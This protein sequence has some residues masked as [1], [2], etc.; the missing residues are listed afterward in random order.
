[1]SSFP[2]HLVIVRAGDRSLHPTWT[3]TPATRTWDLVISYFDND[4]NRFGD[5]PDRRIDDPGLK[6]PGLHA[7]LVRETFWRD[8]DYIW[9]PD[10]D[11]KMAQEGVDALFREMAA[12]DLD[13]AQP[14][15]SLAS[16]FSHSITLHHPHFRARYT[17]FVEIMAPCFRREFLETCLPAFAESVSG[18]GLDWVFPSLRRDAAH[19]CAILDSIEMT[20]TRP[21]GGPSYAVLRERGITAQQEA[22]AVRARYGITPGATPRVLG[23]VT[24][25]G[26]R[27]DGKRPA[28]AAVLEILLANDLQALFAAQARFA[29]EPV[30]FQLL[31]RLVPTRWGW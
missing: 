18:W 7:L 9:L 15:L 3:K 30:R 31:P 26:R 17:N 28:D 2:R 22:A 21:V 19:R 6:Y 8:Y 13:L 5:G 27:L 1:M 25:D 10:D 20:H 12:L 23:A 11:L 16:F 24:A 4:R 29:F 14:A